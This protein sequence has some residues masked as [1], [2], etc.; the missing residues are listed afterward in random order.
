MFR[1]EEKARKLFLSLLTAEERLEWEAKGSIVIKPKRG[2]TRKFLLSRHTSSTIEMKGD[3]HYIRGW[4]VYVD[5]NRGSLPQYD[6]LAAK[7]LALKCN[8]KHFRANAA[9]AQRF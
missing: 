9:L 4:C 6:H 8:L 1:A 7:Y 3:N 2:R 5:M